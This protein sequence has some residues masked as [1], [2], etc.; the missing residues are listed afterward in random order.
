VTA[1]VAPGVAPIH[2]ATNADKTN[3]AGE[4]LGSIK[5]F[6]NGNEPRESA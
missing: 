5:H 6:S 1:A 4:K 2:S 3:R